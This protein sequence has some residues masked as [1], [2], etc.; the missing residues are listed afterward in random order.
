MRLVFYCPVE[1]QCVCN[2]NLIKKGFNMAQNY[3]N[4]T[5][6]ITLKELTPIIRALFVELEVSKTVDSENVFTIGMH[7]DEGSYTWEAILPALAK[8]VGG[9]EDALFSEVVQQ[10]AKSINK[11][12]SNNIVGLLKV[13]DEDLNSTYN[14]TELFELAI[15]L[16][17]GHGL[18]SINEQTGYGCSKHLL[19]EF[20]GD[21]QFLGKEFSYFESSYIAQRVGS[22]VNDAL[23]ADDT[24]AAA[25]VLFKTFFEKSGS[26]VDVEK[27]REVYA[28]LGAMFSA[29]AGLTKEPR[30]LITV[31]GGVADYVADEGVNVH[32]YDH[33]AHEDDEELAGVPAEFSDFVDPD[34]S[35]KVELDYYK[36]WDEIIPQVTVKMNE[37]RQELEA[38]LAQ[39]SNISVSDVHLSKEEGESSVLWIGINMDGRLLIKSSFVLLENDDDTVGGFGVAVEMESFLGTILGGY[40]PLIFGAFSND[41]NEIKERVEEF[42][43]KSLAEFIN[44]STLQNEIL[45]SEAKLAGIQ[46]PFI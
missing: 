21:G 4:T 26:I 31:S 28:K 20:G 13:I 30:V 39:R 43:P 16:D 7:T 17:D 6:E 35:M 3:F 34:S 37:L 29:I 5:G 18:D 19:Y 27:S 10:L 12:L 41:L 40:K 1:S 46:T 42:Y 15:F 11:E 25:E 8:L 14:L 32:I 23:I 33:D 36:T 44:T 2:I 9:A 24:D 22:G 45:V 38:A